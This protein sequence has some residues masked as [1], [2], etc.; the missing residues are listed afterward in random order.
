MIKQEF[1]RYYKSN[2]NIILTVMLI[3]IVVGSYYV[4]YLGKLEWTAVYNSG[5][6]DVDLIRVA[7]IISSYTN[8]AYFEKFIFSGDF[9]VGFWIIIIIGFGVSIGP[10]IYTAMQSN[11]GTMIMTRMSYKKYLIQVLIARIL[12]MVTYVIGFFTVIFA[13]TIVFGKGNV[14]IPPQSIL[15][16]ASFG[17]YLSVLV[18]SILHMLAYSIVLLLITTV[19][20]IFFSNKYIIQMFPFMILMST[21][22]FANTLGNVNRLFEGISHF[23]VIDSI[24]YNIREVLVTS[25]P[26]LINGLIGL[27]FIAIGSII[28]IAIYKEN[29]KRYGRDYIA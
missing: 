6:K 19:S 16:G 22:I 15:F 7:N 18:L 21:Y 20:T 3:L 13:L 9:F 25:H 8:L 17:K 23:I 4:T 5:A 11:Y 28:F 27:T 2:F 29:I 1:K 24:I 26:T 14:Q 10:S 12:Y